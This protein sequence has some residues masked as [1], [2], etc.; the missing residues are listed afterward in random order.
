LEAKDGRIIA[1]VRE[2]EPQGVAISDPGKFTAKDEMPNFVN[3]PV[4]SKTFT[5]MGVQTFLVTTNTTAAKCD[6]AQ[7]ELGTGEQEFTLATFIF[8]ASSSER[9]V[10][11]AGLS[12]SVPETIFAEVGQQV[13]PAAI[14]KVTQDRV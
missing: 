13:Q 2:D 12:S 9:G 5:K 1:I 14:V 10:V 4:T 11:I 7:G 3:S 8:T 6:R